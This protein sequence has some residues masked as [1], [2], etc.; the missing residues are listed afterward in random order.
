MTRHVHLAIPPWMIPPKG[1]SPDNGTQIPLQIPLPEPPRYPPGYGPDERN[2]RRERSDR[3]VYIT[4][5]NGDPVDDED[6]DR[7][8]NPQREDDDR[9]TYKF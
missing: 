9:W 7:R 6:G 4:N 2:N 3:G 8:D 5:I 1:K